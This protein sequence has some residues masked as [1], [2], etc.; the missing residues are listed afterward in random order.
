MLTQIDMNHFYQKLLSIQL[1]PS[2]S[3]SYITGF[4]EFK[5]LQQDWLNDIY[6][7]ETKKIAETASHLLLYG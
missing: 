5:H 2:L 4:Q 1:D 6:F 7:Q 3:I